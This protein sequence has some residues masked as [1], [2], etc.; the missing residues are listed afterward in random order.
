M[1]RE[2]RNI[3]RSRYSANIRK[4]LDPCGTSI[5]AN[6]YRYSQFA[7]NHF[8]LCGFGVQ[9]RKTRLPLHNA[10]NVGSCSCTSSELL[11]KIWTATH[12]T[13]C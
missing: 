7:P 10:T 13:R 1:T 5:D 4:D 11:V 3:T 9:A 6:K 12:Y 2:V 8:E